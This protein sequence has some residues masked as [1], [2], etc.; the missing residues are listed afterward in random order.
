MR[1]SR[2]HHRRDHRALDVQLKGYRL[3][4]A[5]IIYHMPDHP[6]LLQSFVWQLY[7][8]A[9][10]FPELHKFLDFW[11]SNLD[12]PLHSVRVMT[13][14]LIGAGRYRNVEHSFALH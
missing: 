11:R 13:K 1:I 5:E 7:D 14:D 6:E 3:S 8:L 10:D 12:G 2:L 4:T 9:P